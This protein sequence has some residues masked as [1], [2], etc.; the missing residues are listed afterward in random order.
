MT[1]ILLIR[2]AVND[3]V[4]T[5]KLA[6]RM[7]GVRLNDEGL[8]QAEALGQRLAEAPLQSIYSSPM[9]RTLE[10]AAAIA[11]GHPQL[12]VQARTEIIEV[13]YGDWQGMAISAL[14]RRKMWGVVQEY[15]SRAYFPNG[16][17]MRDVQ[18][19]IVNAIESL[20]RQHPAGMIA[21][22]CHA[23]LI[24]L[25]LAHYL[26]MHLDVF[27]RIVISPASISTL[28]LGH[29]RPFILGMNDIAHLLELK[30]AQ[31]RAGANKAA[32]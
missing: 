15:P 22:V 14:Q 8:A 25:A 16:E 26:G 12:T 6:G 24:K 4:T 17:T 1:T 30:K 28:Q 11:R 32:G 20:A 23:D 9:E 2:H 31:K 19:R 3:F 10:T 5:G 7:E 21:L 27:Q 13:E 18:A 29:S